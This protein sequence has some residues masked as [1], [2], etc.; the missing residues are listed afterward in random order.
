M[1]RF[2][3]FLLFFNALPYQLMVTCAGRI[4]TKHWLGAQKSRFAWDRQAESLSPNAMANIA[5]QTPKRHENEVQNQAKSGQ[6]RSRH[7]M[8]CAGCLGAPPWI[9]QGRGV[10]E[11]SYKEESALENSSRSCHGARLKT[12][13]SSAVQLATQLAHVIA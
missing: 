1:T 12:C 6:V 9:C 5:F 4:L 2:S 3:C 10:F 8:T 11:T 7:L 13:V